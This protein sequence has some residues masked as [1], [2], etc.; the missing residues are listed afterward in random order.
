[1][2]ALTKLGK[3]DLDKLINGLADTVT[4][5][6][7][8]AKSPQLKV[9]IDSLPG[10]INR[11]GAA[12]ASIQRLADSA[13]IQLASTTEALRKTSTS[14][15]LAL[16]QTQATLR[17]VRETVGPGS[18]IS[19]QLGQTLSD[20]SQAARAMRDLADYLNRN[21]SAIVRGRPAGSGK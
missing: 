5:I 1:M 11:L 4:Q 21:P 10:A 2:E 6:S 19:Y 13:N 14:A 12:A 18:P 15:T 16:E 9:A 7:E 8:L 3:V 17:G 20:L